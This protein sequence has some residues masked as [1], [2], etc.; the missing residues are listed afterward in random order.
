[1]QWLPPK[2]RCVYSQELPEKVLEETAESLNNRVG[3]GGLFIS[4]PKNGMDDFIALCHGVEIR[5]NKL[6]F[7]LSELQPNTFLEL[8]LHYKNFQVKL[9]IEDLTVLRMERVG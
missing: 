7:Y 1:M 4:Y 8:N 6:M 2:F 3:N 9:D 5:E